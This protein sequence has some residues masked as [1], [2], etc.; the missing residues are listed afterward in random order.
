MTVLHCYRSDMWVMPY[1]L[2]NGVLSFVALVVS[3]MLS[4]GFLQF[5]NGIKEKKLVNR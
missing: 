5:C 2:L 1:I 4:V 3:C